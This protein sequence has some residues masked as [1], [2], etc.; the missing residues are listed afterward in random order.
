MQIAIGTT[1]MHITVTVPACVAWSD[2]LSQQAALSGRHTA[3]PCQ[4]HSPLMQHLHQP[5]ACTARPRL[6]AGIAA[7]WQ[8]EAVDLLLNCGANPDLVDNDGC[9]PK[10][11]ARFHPHMLASMHQQQVQFQIAL[12]QQQHCNK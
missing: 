8:D 11:M 9:T 7:L 2:V 1:L 10:L 6:N 5:Y 3:Q 12:W 4:V